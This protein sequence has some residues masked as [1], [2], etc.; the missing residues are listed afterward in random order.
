MNLTETVNIR[1]IC[2]CLNSVSALPCAGIPFALFF[3]GGFCH[4]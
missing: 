1:L 4:T 3:T 2:G